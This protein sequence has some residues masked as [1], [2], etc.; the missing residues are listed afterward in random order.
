MFMLKY[1]PETTSKEP[2]QI[3][4]K[5]KMILAISLTTLVIISCILYLA[6]IS[7]EYFIVIAAILI[8]ILSVLKIVIGVWKIR[9]R[10]I[11]N[12]F[13]LKNI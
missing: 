4:I 5:E 13:G 10:N 9:T 3:T 12:G 6:F 1:N 2:S 11:Q 8:F 7:R